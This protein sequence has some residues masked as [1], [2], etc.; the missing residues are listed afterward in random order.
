MIL[1]SKSKIN[2][3]LKVLNKRSD[4][5]HNIVTIFQE[6]DFGD[7]IQLVKHK[8]G[9]QIKSDVDWIP[10][11]NS[12]ICHKAYSALCHELNQDF[13]VK[14]SLE[15]RIPVGS[16]IGGGSAN[17]ATTLIGLNSLYNLGLNDKK[18]E[19]IAVNIGA[20][21]P[22]FIKGGTQIGQ[23]TGGKLS[24]ITK[25]LE[26]AV[27][28]VIPK[29]PIS[30]E[31]AYSQLKNKLKSDNSILRFVD[32]MR[33]DFLSFKFFENDFEKIVIPAYPEIGSIKN[34]LLDSGAKFA[35]LSGSGSTVFG[36]FDDNVFAKKAESYFRNSHLTILTRP[37]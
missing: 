22:F 19:S 1:R 17:A 11:D 32:L 13:G 16:G 34:K 20:D 33:K 14:I 21:V 36:I 3:G 31:W 5:L 30:T 6:V 24:P 28:L 4:G 10:V 37:I 7:K 23:E 2:L 29:V 27:L 12:N 15:K 35:S 26:A 8:T 25:K 9:C 18:L